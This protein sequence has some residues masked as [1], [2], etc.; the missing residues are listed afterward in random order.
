MSDASL[1]AEGGGGDS[2]GIHSEIPVLNLRWISASFSS[3]FWEWWLPLG[4]LTPII[5]QGRI[6]AACTRLRLC[7]SSY[8]AL[9]LG[10]RSWRMT[11][12]FIAA[13]DRSF[14]GGSLWGQSGHIA[15]SHEQR[16]GSHSC[17]D[18]AFSLHVRRAEAYV[19]VEMWGST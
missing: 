8:M 4:R 17:E 18:V 14:S 3:K 11:D 2:H 7:G 9:R 10:H 19:F 15:P 12:I 13:V 1:R 5:S 16:S 6:S